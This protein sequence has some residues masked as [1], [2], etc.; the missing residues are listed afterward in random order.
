MDHLVDG[1][2]EQQLRLRP[3]GLNSLAWIFWHISRVEDGFVN[4]VVLGRDQLFD[5]DNWSGRLRVSTRDVSTSKGGVG[6]LS[7]SI[8]LD[9]LWA[10][11]NAVGRS[12]R[13][14]V[15]ALSPDQWDAPI[16]V[17]DVRRAVAAGICSADMEQFLTGKSRESAL[18][19][20]GLHHTLMHLGQVS[21][22]RPVVRAL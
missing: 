12:T 10:Y 15:A 22:L 21:M 6:E 14:G 13:E 9:V 20:W 17:S 4:C 16:E 11:R 8:D 5:Q 7:D 18:H 1:L 3:H 19:W 2:T